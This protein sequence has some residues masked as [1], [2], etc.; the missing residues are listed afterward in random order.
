MRMLKA[1]DFYYLPRVNNLKSEYKKCESRLRELEDEFDKEI[2]FETC[3]TYTLNIIS[4]KIF[5]VKEIM[6]AIMGQI[7]RLQSEFCN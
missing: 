7:K 6:K 2:Y 4:D 3:S 1:E 5:T